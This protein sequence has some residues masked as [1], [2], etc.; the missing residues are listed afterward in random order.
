MSPLPITHYQLPIT[1]YQTLDF[2]EAIGYLHIVADKTSASLEVVPAQANLRLWNWTKLSS[3]FAM[4][5]LSV[6]LTLALLSVAGQTFALEKVG[7]NGAG[8]TNIQQCLKKL[9][10]F[11]G[12]VS[13][14]FGSITQQAV[15]AFQQANKLPADGVVGNGTARSL[16]QACQGR[17]ASNTSGNLRLGSR[18]P[19]VIKLQ[20][21]L[22]RLGYFQGPITGYFG[23]QTQQA[24]IR[25]QQS[26]R[27]PTR[28][29]Q[30]PS[31]TPSAGGEYPILLEGSQGPAVTRL[32]QRLQQLGY[33][34]ANPTGKF[35]RITKDAVIA[36]QRNA[37]L[38]A[39][40][41]TNRQTWN[42]LVSPTSSS[43]NTVLPNT[44]SL[45]PQQIRELQ[46]GLRQLGYL[47]ANPTGNF[48]PLTREGLIRFQRDYQL[49]A[50]GVADTQALQAVRGVLQ[51]RQANQ[52]TQP[53]RNYLT[54]GDSGDN[55][56]AIQQRL[57]Q[58]GFFNTNPDGY[59][60]ENTKS[61]VYAFQQYSGINPTGNV[62]AQTWQ[63][64]GLN[65]SPVETGS[66][67]NQNRYVVVVP[68]HNADTL[69]KVRQYIANP[70]VE[71]SG[72]GDYVNAGRFGNRAE[73]ENLSK[74]LRSY[75][76]DARV[77][78]F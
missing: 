4:R 70:V 21:R 17:I 73:A 46:E 62:D 66:N 64:L 19:E 71:K 54:V 74:L 43:S 25:S 11:R 39:D 67:N 18:G 53:S 42:R 60:G 16:Q 32:Q 77:E 2:M 31:N 48:G 58:L 33:F 45:T 35:G 75:G 8:V 51:N 30:A 37:G 5:F 28:T 13:G 6:A 76:L 36:F 63:A 69:N 34:N 1:N 68:I 52:V 59:Y 20:Q 40:G 41:I 14:K 44:T 49:A 47:Q 78:Y 55:V 3:A 22:Q 65:T 27:N 24:L 72:L 23:P 10:F 12:P 7:S 38:P 57:L 9:G 15:I 26:S 50:D 61:Y 29:P 56:K